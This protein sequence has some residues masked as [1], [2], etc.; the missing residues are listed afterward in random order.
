MT[1]LDT[2]V[3]IPV[4]TPVGEAE[5]L[6]LPAA[7]SV[8]RGEATPAAVRHVLDGFPA[9][10]LLITADRRVAY[11]ND[12]AL[13]D[14]RPIEA[15]LPVPLD[16]WIGSDVLPLFAL[17]GDVGP[18]DRVWG[19]RSLLPFEMPIELGPETARLSLTAVLADGEYNGLMIS[20]F[21]TTEVTSAQ[22]RFQRVHAMLEN[23]PTKMMFANTDGVITYLN[24]ACLAA[25]HDL[26]PHMVVPPEQFVGIPLHMLYEEPDVQR[27]VLADPAAI[28]AALEE[29]RERTSAISS[30]Y[31][32]LGPEVLDTWIDEMR[33]ESGEH[34]GFLLTWD[35]VTE[36][37]RIEH[38]R[39]QAMADTSAMN[40][41]LRLVGTATSVDEAIGRTLQAVCTEFGWDYA[42]CWRVDPERE[43]LRFVTVCGDVSRSVT[44]LLSGSTFR[45]GSGLPGRTWAAGDVILVDGSELPPLFVQGMAE[46]GLELRSGL[47]FPVKVDGEVIATMDFFSGS[48]TDFSGQRLETLRN[49]AD[50]VS[51][52]VAR[53][54]RDETDRAAAAELAAKVEL[55]L[56][57]VRAIGEGDLTRDIT[58][59]GDDAIG[60]LAS[61]LADVVSTLRGS[62]SDIGGT[63]DSLAVAADQLSILS[64]GMGEGAALTSE[65]AASASGSSTQVSSSIQTVATAVEEMTAS[66]REIAKN[67]T[68]AATVA[69]TAV[70]VASSAQ[71]TVASLGESSAEIG[72]VIKVITS[73][74]QQTNL[75]ALNATI[76]AARAGDAGKGFAVVA[77]EVKELAKETARATED[78]GQKI[79]AIQSDT[80]GAVTAIREITDVIGRINDIQ[81]TIASAVER[82]TATTNEIARSVTDAAAG[83]AGIAEDVG[84]VAT[85]AEDTRHG[86]NNIMQSATNLASFAGQLRALVNRFRV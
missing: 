16:D 32:H 20:W 15:F 25:F 56:D 49:I 76:E 52:A 60:Q 14:L 45:L 17:L 75:L 47:S 13:K 71:G 79:D 85:A 68:E 53:I 42:S 9:P 48:V 73:I 41:V 5:L 31:V 86:S 54:E 19:D 57:V 58:V 46:H 26:G 77:N 69:T 28:Q 37:L 84:E 39:E 8:E 11:V 40:Q 12:Q 27:A 22:R 4:H 62:M 36:K 67:A 2:P 23:S 43:R 44:A 29:S 81:T 3:D 72:K 82:Q 1:D 21:K 51:Q 10:V 63:A 59:S 64:Q 6:L 61:G 55:V 65:R 18:F 80:Q 50:L 30:T 33:N 66:I 78:I 38:D 7:T 70:A 35:L 74:A 83:A 24:P 34:I